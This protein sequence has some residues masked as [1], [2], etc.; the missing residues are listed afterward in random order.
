MLS[1]VTTP[2]GTFR[3]LSRV[4][5]TTP[6]D[7]AAGR[8]QAISHDGLMLYVEVLDGGGPGWRIGTVVQCSPAQLTLD[9]P[10][11]LA[12]LT[13]RFRED[14]T[15]FTDEPGTGWYVE[16]HELSATARARGIQSRIILWQLTDAAAADTDL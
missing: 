14:L 7:Q 11:T 3:L 1:S 9:P 16:H 10:A 8:V 12:E 5:I 2:H 4:H 13:E 15:A 6:G